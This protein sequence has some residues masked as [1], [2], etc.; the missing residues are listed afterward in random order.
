MIVKSLNENTTLATVGEQ[1]VREPET[2]QAP[3]LGVY[4]NNTSK[5]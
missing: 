5:R 2:T 4:F 3:L 1:F